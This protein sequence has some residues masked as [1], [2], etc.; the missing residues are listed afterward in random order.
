MHQQLP[1]GSVQEFLTKF[2]NAPKG[3]T[4]EAISQRLIFWIE[5]ANNPEKYTNGDSSKFAVADVRRKARQNVRRIVTQHPEVA[6]V[7]A[8]HL[9]AETA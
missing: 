9:K 7:V 6:V 1:T 8:A 3:K 5:R 4:P 2:L